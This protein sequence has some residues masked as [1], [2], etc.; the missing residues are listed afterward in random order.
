V[1]S[2]WPHTR[3]VTRDWWASRE[4]FELFASQFV[5]DEAAA[6][7]VGAATAGLA[8]LDETAI[9][10][11]TE[12]AILLAEQLIAGGGLP[13]QARIDA[14]HVA[15]A[16]V[17]GMDYLL[18]WNCRHIANAALRGKIEGLCREAGVDPPTICTP[19]ELPKE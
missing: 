7:D 14:L 15:M 6:G 13:A 19:L 12:Q 8:V 3:Q 5:L 4:Y 18:T 10:D 11:V 9:L 16:A 1:T 17:H 2:C